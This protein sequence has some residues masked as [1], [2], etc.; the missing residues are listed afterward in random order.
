MKS[1]NEKDFREL[2]AKEVELVAGGSGTS[3]G[4]TEVYSTMKPNGGTTTD[5]KADYRWD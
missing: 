4:T 1:I 5:W 3:E 2:D